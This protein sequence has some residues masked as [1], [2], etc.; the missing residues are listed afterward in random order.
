MGFGEMIWV[1][2][3]ETDLVNIGLKCGNSLGGFDKL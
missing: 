1:K 2:I 3:Y